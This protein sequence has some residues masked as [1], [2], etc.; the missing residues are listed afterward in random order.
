MSHKIHPGTRRIL[1]ASN[2]PLFAEG[3]RSLLHQREQMDA[4]VVGVV[5]T[6]EQ[7]LRALSELQPDLIVIDYDDE[8]VNRDEFLAR[9][10]EGESRLRVVLLSLQEGGQD[11]V[12]YDRRTLAASQVDEWLK[13]WVETNRGAAE[14]SPDQMSA[15]QK[16]QQRRDGMKHFI[17]AVF[18]I[19]ILALAGFVGLQNV[20]LL[21]QPASLQAAPIDN[22][23]QLDFT[24]II[25]LFALIVGLMVYS[26]IFFR[27]R[28]S[29]D[30]DGPYITGNTRLEVIW[31]IVPL[32]F[33]LYLAYVG[34]LALGRTQAADPRPLRV[35]VVASQWAWRFDYPDI[36]VTSTELVLPVNKQA[37]LSLSSTDVIHSFWVPEFRVKQDAL[38]GEDFERELRVTPTEIGE[39]KVRCAE[40]CGRQHY[41][42]LATVRVLS[43]EDYDAWVAAQVIPE[44]PIARGDLWSQQFGCRACHS[45]DGTPLVG[46][47]WKG[48]FG[49]QVLLTDGTSA[50]VDRAYIIES[51]RQPGAKIVAGFQDLMPANIGADLT[52]EQIDDIIAFIESLK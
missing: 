2:H 23:F 16:Q 14:R 17:G 26:I 49:E 11:A 47:T 48:V 36:G 20:E 22:L 21:P 40:L 4:I 10:V 24:A 45:I 5:S 1:I 33:V 43:Q 8:R 7:A 15:K 34:S 52:D 50:L 12:V 42:M 3:L 27:R 9:F 25:V 41:N 18:L 28:R 19:V 38:P 29:D 37:L 44:D 31:T 32:G 46:P 39:F 30:Q 6:I 51:I 13:E 35:D